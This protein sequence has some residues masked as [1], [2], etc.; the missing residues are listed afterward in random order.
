MK[1]LSLLVFATCALSVAA[2]DSPTSRA[3]APQA[4][5]NFLLLDYHGKAF[6]LQRAGGRAVV[7]FFTGNGCPIAR[8]SI[9]KIRELRKKLSDQGVTFWMVNSYSQDDRESI[10][11]E[12]EQFK[13]GSLPVLLDQSQSLALALGVQRTCEAIAINTKGGSIF[14]RGGID[15]QL[16]E[17]AQKPGPTERYLE[18][19]LTEFLA[20]KQISQAK[21]PVHGC[22]I[23]FEKVSEQSDAGVSYAK[24]V[25]PVL[26]AKCVTCHSE[27]NIGPF[28]M[29]SYAKVKNK[30]RMIE[31][32][33][34]AKRMP[35]WHADPHYGKFENDRSLTTVETQTLLRWIQQGAPRG[36][37]ADP[38]EKAMVEAVE[39]PLGKPDYIIRLPQP[40]EVPAT[41]VL[42]YRHILVKSPVPQDTWLA[43]VDVRPGNRKVVHHVIA[44]MKFKGAHDDGSGRGSPLVGWAPGA[45]V[46]RFPAG[47]GKFIAKDAVLDLELH[48][49]TMG[50]PQTDQTEIALYALP[51]KPGV[52]L[53]DRAALDTDFSI[54]P[55][56]TDARTFG[57]FGFKRDSL[58]YTF[59]PHM[60]LRGS[61]MK[62]EALYPDGNREILLSVPRYDF[63]WQTTYRLA[64]PKR[65]PK[66][67]WIL[68]TGGF[69]NSP[70][71]PSNPDAHKRVKWGDQSWDE[72]FIGFLQV[73]DVPKETPALSR[74]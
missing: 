64:T 59:S 44:R 41:G 21:A 47:T 68:C 14:Y 22:L 71:N 53:E 29:S 32:V 37:G 62:Y 15:D 10:R 7:L 58:I 49:T 12:A 9:P 63:N 23:A 42:D 20:G 72:M 4:V 17:G 28:A 40:E 54:P 56:E 8:Q 45:T 36:E 43:A 5:P 16:A 19:A 30:S 46:A 31:E 25:A 1:P 33:V 66:G 18:T 39:W 70:Q 6:E 48:Y 34:A 65:V 51:S 13:V 11:K 38:L 69:D 74:N 3:P 73:S 35:P 61:W 57:V 26:H 24:D 55:G 50:S 2:A 27:G 52:A 60:H 67:T